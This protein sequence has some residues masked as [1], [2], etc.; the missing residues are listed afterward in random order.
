MLFYWQR[1]R[2]A[3][4]AVLHLVSPRY[5][6]LKLVPRQREAET[7]E[8]VNIGQNDIGGQRATPENPAICGHHGRHRLDVDDHRLGFG[9]DQ[10][11]SDRHRPELLFSPCRSSPETLAQGED[12]WKR[13]SLHGSLLPCIWV[14]RHRKAVPSGA[15]HNGTKNISCVRVR[16]G[17]S[18]EPPE[19]RQMPGFGTGIGADM[20]L[21]PY[22]I[23]GVVN[24]REGADL[25]VDRPAACTGSVPE[26]VLLGR[27][28]IKG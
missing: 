18:Q 8:L 12:E 24:D 11:T 26:Q 4:E 10:P 6:H 16:P 13:S 2:V 3:P 19:L 5:G 21:F 28:H 15:G 25:W 22:L 20:L 7:V 23:A 9:A 14:C 1:H 17:R 27:G